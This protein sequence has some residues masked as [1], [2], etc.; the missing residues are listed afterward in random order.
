MGRSSENAKERKKNSFLQ[1]IWYDW[2]GNKSLC[3]HSE[4][5]EAHLI[6]L[7][8]DSIRGRE[9]SSSSPR[10]SPLGKSILTSE[11]LGDSQI[12]G[13][14]LDVWGLACLG[15]CVC[16]H[17]LLT[18]M[19]DECARLDF[20]NFEERK[21]YLE[22]YWQSCLPQYKLYED[23]HGEVAR[24]AGPFLSPFTS[25]RPSGGVH[26]SSSIAKS[27]GY[28]A[29]LPSKLCFTP[30]TKSELASSCQEETYCYIIMPFGLKNVDSR[31]TWLQKKGSRS[32]QQDPSYPGDET[33]YNLNEVQKLD[34][35][36]AALSSG[37]GIVLTSS[38]GDE[39]EYTLS[40][41]FKSSN[42]EVEHET[43]IAGI[44]MALD[45]RAR[46]LIA[47]S[48]SQL[49]TNKVRG[50]YD[51]KEDGMKRNSKR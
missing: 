27:N 32:C 34:G 42:N 29:G 30:M 50:M 48:G 16:V 11:R 40:F 20:P 15:E 5:D 23:L 45:A 37:V 39:M 21:Q 10:K 9:T 8:L 26:L 7:A 33:S 22:S 12:L 47:Y 19:G 36:I 6:L 46:N 1:V 28:L 49:V 24:I 18:L 44:K 38:K 14:R 41:E 43:L 2:K 25:Y 3:L 4:E 51:V 31:D 35:C 13:M 17:H